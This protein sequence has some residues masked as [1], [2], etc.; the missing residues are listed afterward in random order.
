MRSPLVESSITRAEA[1]FVRRATSRLRRWEPVKT[2]PG[3][4]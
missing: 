3:D 4:V 1:N 2:A